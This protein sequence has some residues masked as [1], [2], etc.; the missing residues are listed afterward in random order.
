MDSEESESDDDNFDQPG[1]VFIPMHSYV[2]KP[3][4]NHPGEEDKA[5]KKFTL[6]QDKVILD[7]IIEILPG[8]RLDYLELSA[9]SSPCKEVARRIGRTE[10]SIQGR[11]KYQLRIWL[12]EYYSKKTKSWTGFTVKASTERRKAVADYFVQELRKRRLKMDDGLTAQPKLAKA[13]K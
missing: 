7:K 12:L 8:Q 2:Q 10:S 11:W 6:D 5:R 3:I 9:A 1:S 13:R 4:D